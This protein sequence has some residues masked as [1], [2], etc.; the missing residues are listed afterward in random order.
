MMI[1]FGDLGNYDP[2]NSLASLMADF[3]LQYLHRLPMMF[4]PGVQ[5]RDS[6]NH[7][8]SPF[9]DY[10]ILGHL[11]LDRLLGILTQ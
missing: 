3:S 2:G 10:N 7:G 11:T 4:L 8:I 5:L 1:G 9:A 6:R